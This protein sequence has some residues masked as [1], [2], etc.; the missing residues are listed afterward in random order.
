MLDEPGGDKTVRTFY[1]AV[2]R[3]EAAAAGR[4]G[5]A[6]DVR[7]KLLRRTTPHVSVF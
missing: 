2:L 4:D 6:V 5:Y 7:K 3:K 1:A